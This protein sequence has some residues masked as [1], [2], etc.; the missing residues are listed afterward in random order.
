[1]S[2]FFVS[3]DSPEGW[4]VGLARPSHWKPGHSAHSLAYTWHPVDGFPPS[5]RGAFADSELGTLEFIAG[6]PEYKV[7]LPGGE[8]ASQTDLFV[9]ARTGEAETV[10]I[11]VEGKARE[12][13]GDK[14]VTD[15]RTGGSEGKA[16]RLRFLLE[17]LGLVDDEEAIGELRYQLLHRTASPLIEAERLA[18]RHAVMLVHSFGGENKWFDEFA[19]FASLLG[20]NTRIGEVSRA[21]KSPRP[22][23]LGWISDP[24]PVTS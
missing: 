21:V 10:A 13:F 15:W 3:P 8:T 23:W 6:I 1:V 12:A 2:K 16:T 22:L 18:A 19:S 24:H 11:A 7:A 14:T 20:A 9:L 17:V 5:V 4:K